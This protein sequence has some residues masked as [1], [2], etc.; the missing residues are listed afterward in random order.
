MDLSAVKVDIIIPIYNAFEELI[1]CIHSIEK[2]TNLEKYRLILINDNSTDERI[3]KFLDSFQKENI[4]VV[5]NRE[6]KGFSANINIGMEQSESHD[7]ILLNSDTVVT[8]N[9][10]EKLVACAYSA[11]MIATVTPLS[12]NATLCSVPNFCEENKVPEEYTVDEY[13]E[14]IENVS[15]RLYPEIPVANGF[16]M[17]VKR[18]VIEDIGNFDAETFERG[19]GEENDFC[20]RAIEVGYHHVMCDDT[21]ILHTGTSSFV[22]EEKQ[23]YIEA[24]E[25]ILDERYP[26]LMQ[27]VRV[28]CRDN[29]NAMVSENIRFWTDYKKVT[30]R[31]TIMYLVQSDFKADADDNVGG[32]QLHVK[33]LTNGLRNKYDVLVAARNDVYLNLTLYTGKQEFFFKYYIG[34]AE[35]F[36]RFR[37]EKFAELYRKILDAFHVGCVHI[38]H[39]KGLS[40][41]L[42]YEASKK[43]IPV[44]ATMHDYYYVCPNVKLLDENNVLCIGSE[45]DEHCRKCLKVQLGAAET[46]PYV[47]IWRRENLKALHLA[48]EIFVPSES[49]KRIVSEY[50]VELAPKIRV[51]EHGSD[52]SEIQEKDKNTGKSFRV[53]FIG[54][55]STAKG[56]RYAAELIKKGN[57]DIHWYLFGTFER[58][59]GAVERK[60]NFTNVGA[61]DRKDLPQLMKKYAI[62][63][64]CILPIWP[65]TF[66]YTIS[67]AVLCG[68]PVLVTD[69]G[70]LGDRVREMDCGWVVAHQAST[71]EVLKKINEIKKNKEEYQKKLEYIPTIKIRNVNEMCEIY[72]GIYEENIGGQQPLWSKQQEKAEWLLSGV[73]NAK[74]RWLV[75]NENAREVE[76]HLKEVQGKLFEIENSITYRILMRIRKINIP[77]KN[78]IKVWFTKIYRTIRKRK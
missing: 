36:E 74:G 33:D 18:K 49:A 51:I 48:K 52:F 50:F 43:G 10:V 11:D 9:W 63:L 29:P 53:A 62:D 55:I 12:N 2:W 24:H 16:C 78:H 37:S 46:V 7:V 19:Y 40:L 34:E 35:E 65:E 73:M 3:R 69:I 32:T 15:M 64:V 47:S 23:R 72:A 31:K 17:Y 25:K 13:A 71:D 30:R 70:A 54:G 76:C 5:H 41:E 14:L 60:H 44:F 57:R 4:V 20:Y 68:V 77:G 59:D 39:T 28:H 27:A 45:K 26:K 58:Y 6:N 67:E 21:F 56:Y 22:S 66:C 8:R 38:H 42:Y 61:Y 75:L 1:R